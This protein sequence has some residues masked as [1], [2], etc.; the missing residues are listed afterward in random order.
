M[1][2]K[3][4]TASTSFAPHLDPSCLLD[5]LSDALV[6][7]DEAGTIQYAN[8]QAL[9]MIG[10]DKQELLGNTLWQCAPLLV[11][12]PF[13]QAVT[14]ALQTR[15]PFRIKY[16]SP[17]TLAWFWVQLSPTDKGLALF[18]HQV[19]DA[20]QFEETFS[21]N[22]PLYRDLLES[23]PDGVAILTPDGL[24]LDMNQHSL[25]DAQIQREEVIGKPLTD[26]PSWSYDPALQQQ[27]RA[28]IERASR[29]DT[30]RFRA[31]IRSRPGVY[32]DMVMTITPH[33]DP[34]QQV[35]C[36]I[37]AGRDITRLKKAKTDLHTFLDAIPHF[38]WMMRS[39]G[40]AEYGNQQLNDYTNLP[41]EQTRGNGWLLFL[42]PDDRPSVLEAWQTSV[43]TGAP[44]EVVHR[45]RNGRTGEYRW[46]LARGRPFRDSHGT[47][48]RWIGTCTD[49]DEQKQVEQ[50][51]KESRERWQ[52]LAE[53]IP[54]MVWTSAPDGS[55]TYGNQRFYEYFN[56]LPEHLLGYGWRQFL[57]PDD[58]ERTLAVR[59]QSLKTGSSYEIEY[60]LRN[61]RTGYYRWFLSRAM[62]VRDETG[63]IVTWFGTSTDIDEQKRVEEALRQSQARI[64]ALMNSSLIG[65]FVSE[66]GQV[67][68]ANETYLRM[69]GYT[70][71]DLQAGEI[72][73]MRL[74]SPEE[75]TRTLQAIEELA[76]PPHVSR[77]EE[78]YIRKDGRRLPVV[79]GMV[80]FHLDPLQMIG[81]VL[82]DSAQRELEQRK[83]AFI[84]MAS[85]E[86]RTPLTAIKGNLQLIEH[87]MQKILNDKQA[88]LSLK[89]RDAGEHIELFVQRALRQTNVESR[90][91][92]DLLDATAI[93]SNTLQVILE[94]CDLGRIVRDAVQDLLILT[95]MQRIDVQV[96]EYLEI[97]VTADSIRIGQ[98]ITSY[99]T[100]AIKYSDMS[101][102]VNVGISL[103]ADEARVWVKDRGPGVALETQ[104][105]IWDRFSPIGDF[106]TYKDRGGGGLG[107]SL[108]ISQAIIH[109]HGGRVGVESKPG[110]GATFWFLLP[111]RN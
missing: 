81:F 87:R 46:F 111:L 45:I 64:N 29:G 35:E 72:N 107:L 68:E 32:L 33:C 78:E 54:Q 40:S 91:L 90:L 109:Q 7:L 34:P 8:T 52:A 4:P 102:T 65:I 75:L 10:M 23:F 96:P 47:I 57:H 71:E 24:V 88:S 22:E 6:F 67:I 30:A 69:T 99:L 62:P 20:E 80:A 55:A 66:K 3:K 26:F 95:E 61:G 85:H 49:I 94:P 13:Y 89:E 5:T 98:V 21:C 93:R 28:A 108:Y 105:H 41:S 83:D 76:A 82:D 17:V 11:T 39:D 27:L 25:D 44:Y 70:Q 77:S 12:T 58:Y 19:G 56:T 38:V 73:W 9:S 37:C 101:Q 48:L 86:L 42:H 84:C 50:Q 53:T 1:S 104:E 74:T 31:R 79:V 36:L 43:R 106:T 100:N 110:H 97:P 103:E 2:D 18:F 63:Q 16:H 60:R 92:N 51:L 59:Q 14:K 15:Q